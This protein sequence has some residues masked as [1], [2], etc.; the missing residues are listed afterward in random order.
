MQITVPTQAGTIHQTPVAI[1]GMTVSR[2]FVEQMPVGPVTYYEYDLT[3]AQ[4]RAM[5]T[6]EDLL[7]RGYNMRE[8]V[9]ALRADPVYALTMD[10]AM[11]EFFLGDHPLSM[12]KAEREAYREARKTAKR[13]ARWA[14][15]QEDEARE[16][17]NLQAMA[18]V[19]GKSPT[20]A[21]DD[22]EWDAFGIEDRF[23]PA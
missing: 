20:R 11:V 9:M 8:A 22:E 1:K 18:L 6:F 2:T 21:S 19:A 14:K 13:A 23:G 3:A 12:T 4:T 17:R 16:M 7:D 10:A 15:R 5:D